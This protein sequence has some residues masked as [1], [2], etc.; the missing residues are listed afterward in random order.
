[1]GK[2]SQAAERQHQRNK[3]DQVKGVRVCK[4]RCSRQG[5]QG[6]LRDESGRAVGKGQKWLHLGGHGEPLTYPQHH[7]PR[8]I[9]SGVWEATCTVGYCEKTHVLRRMCIQKEM[10]KGINNPLVKIS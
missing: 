5:V 4:M 7:L 10:F 8:L 9:L 3:G 2:G 1:M 6:K